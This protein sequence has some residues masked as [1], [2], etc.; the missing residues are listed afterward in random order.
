M[1]NFDT[2]SADVLAA[3]GGT[4]Q[5]TVTRGPLRGLLGLA[6]V[7][8]NLD[9]VTALDVAG[10][11]VPKLG[12]IGKG[13]GT[14]MAM[15]LFFLGQT[16]PDGASLTSTWTLSASAALCCLYGLRG[17]HDTRLTGFGTI[18]SDSV[19]NPSVEV[20]AHKE[21]SVGIIGF[22]SG[23]TGGVGTIAPLANW[24]SIFELDVGPGIMQW[25]SYSYDLIQSENVTHGWTQ[26]AEDALAWGVNMAEFTTLRDLRVA[27]GNHHYLSF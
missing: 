23:H 12:H 22:T 26:T 2:A 25:A 17:N 3:P 18:S 14:A 11:S 10:T 20:N 9:V 13:T 6:W 1:I 24:T 21:P 4:V 19:A 7:P 5:Y 27:T 8:A 15:S 16:I